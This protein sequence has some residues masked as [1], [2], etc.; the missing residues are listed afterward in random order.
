MSEDVHRKVAGR[1]WGWA[2][3]AVAVAAVLLLIGVE[4]EPM[5][6]LVLLVVAA[7]VGVPL[8]L[9]RHPGAFA[10]VCLGTGALVLPLGVFCALFGVFAFLAAAPMLI[11]AACADGRHRPGAGWVVLALGTS[12]LLTVGLLK[13]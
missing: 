1:P 13:L 10:A 4:G 12:V 5:A 6:A 9:R 11:A 8:L 3:A 2:V 7:P